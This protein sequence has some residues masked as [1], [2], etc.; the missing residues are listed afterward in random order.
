MIAAAAAGT[1][2]VV[3]S[4]AATV[5]VAANEASAVISNSADS[6]FASLA[7]VTVTLPSQWGVKLADGAG[8]SS[9]Q[10]PAGSTSPVTV[11]LVSSGAVQ[12]T[13]TVSVTVS[14]S[15]GEDCV[16]VTG[17]APMASPAESPLG[18]VDPAGPAVTSVTVP[19]LPSSA[20]I[21]HV[22]RHC[23][24]LWSQ[25]AVPLTV[26]AAAWAGR[27]TANAPKAPMATTVAAVNARRTAS[28]MWT[29][30]LPGVTE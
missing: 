20:P 4:P 26:S 3:L 18:V 14:A 13:A 22:T 9:T 12:L 11:W 30:R 8:W 15:P 25:L 17:L 24:V 7:S 16:T 2:T 21:D 1:S 6:T 5:R 28:L 29:I 19:S 27:A 23:P 10:V